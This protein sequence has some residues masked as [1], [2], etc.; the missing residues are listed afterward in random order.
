MSR[1]GKKP[2]QIPEGVKIT[3]DGKHISVTGAKGTLELDIHPDIDV[4]QENSSLLVSRPSDSKTHRALHGTMRAL[5]QNMV[6]GTSNGFSKEL[7]IQGVGYRA[8]MEGQRLKL[9][10]G[11]SHDIYFEPPEGIQ[12]SAG[13]NKITVS[14]IDKQLVGQVAAKIRSF[15]S[16]ESYKGK[17]IRY[18]DEYVRIK[19]GKTI[20]GVGA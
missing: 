15:R 11:Y 9:K 7:S 2:I 6:T 5:L 3:L 12:I 8:D 18:V 10:L 4:V 16:P 13:R 1:V 14:G 19:K 17:G 20:G